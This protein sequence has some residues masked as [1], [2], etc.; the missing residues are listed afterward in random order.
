MRE[1]AGI[2]LVPGYIEEQGF[3]HSIRKECQNNDAKLHAKLVNI[4]QG[5]KT[6]PAPSYLLQN[7]D[8]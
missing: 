4:L 1:S 8:I 6:T 5:N 3:V 2:M 7:H